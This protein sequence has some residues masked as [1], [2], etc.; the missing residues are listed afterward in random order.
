M[1]SAEIN[2]SSVNAPIHAPLDLLSAESEMVCLDHAV[3]LLLC[4]LRN[5]YVDV[6]SRYTNL[7]PLLSVG[8]FSPLNILLLLLFCFLFR[9]PFAL[10]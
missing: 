5:L 1:N 10:G 6:H 8:K 2:I 9:Q 3:A 4:V 7:H